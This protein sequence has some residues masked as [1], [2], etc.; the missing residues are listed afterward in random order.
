MRYPTAVLGT[1]AR[2]LIFFKVAAKLTRDS[3]SVI[4]LEVK[5]GGGFVATY[6]SGSSRWLLM[7]FI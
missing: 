2:K 4:D 7:Q 5:L 6:T 3:H 1:V